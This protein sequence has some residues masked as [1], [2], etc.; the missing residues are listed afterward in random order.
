MFETLVE[1]GDRRRPASRAGAFA[2]AIHVGI[3]GLAVN[4]TARGTPPPV[5]PDPIEITIY[6]DPATPAPSS[7]AV[8]SAP[9][10][11]VPTTV[12]IDPP[13]PITIDPV[14]FD[15]IIPADAVSDLRRSIVNGTRIVGIPTGIGSSTLPP[16]DGVLLAGEVD[17][18]VRVL[19]PVLPRYPRA[20]EVAGIPGRVVLQFVVDTTGAVE[21]G[22]LGVAD[23]SDAA[24]VAPSRDAILATRFAPARARGHAVRQLV[25]QSLLF[26]SNRN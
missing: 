20:M 23:F 21:P 2:F 6:E 25:R 22:S 1:S 11:P 14:N 3:V 24:F 5:R 12:S 19:T 16:D 8:A 17:E 7:G 26:R 9:A 18:P 13:G 15:S 10:M 4:Q